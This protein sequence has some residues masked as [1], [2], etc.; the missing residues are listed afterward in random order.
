[1]VLAGF[2]LGALALIASRWSGVAA[3]CVFLLV[4]WVLAESATRS[5]RLAISSTLLFLTYIGGVYFALSHASDFLREH[6]TRSDLAPSLVMNGLVAAILVVTTWLHWVR[7]RAPV[8]PGA[9]A[10]IVILWLVSLQGQLAE[11]LGLDNRFGRPPWSLV[12]LAAGIAV[13][14]K[15]MLLDLRDPQRQSL[16]SDIAF[17][18]HFVAA[19]LAVSPVPIIL[20]MTELMSGA[21]FSW[22]RLVFVA[23]LINFLLLILFSLAI[24]RRAYLFFGYFYYCVA[25]IATGFNERVEFGM[26][27]FLA[28][29]PVVGLALCWG[30]ARSRVLGTL[31]VGL[32]ARLSAPGE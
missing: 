5:R 27:F 4:S 21:M 18:L 22:Q 8:A 32:R 15:A 3:G 16:V 11:R 29:G 20:I 25:T 6:S 2:G 9:I 26:V 23:A 7:F 30:T 10:A 13:F 1:M 19:A 31:P 24:N 14:V 12:I 28:S 17:W